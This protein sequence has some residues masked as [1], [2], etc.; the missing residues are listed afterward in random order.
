MLFAAAIVFSFVASQVVLGQADIPCPYAS[1]PDNVVHILDASYCPTAGRRCIVNKRCQV[2]NASGI[3][4][5]QAVGSL[6]ASKDMELI[7]DGKGAR[8]DLSTLELP[9]AMAHL[10][11][12]NFT[13]F[14]LPA[15]LVWPPNLT[16]LVMDYCDLDTIPS[17]LPRTLTSL[18]ISANSLQS[19]SELRALPLLYPA[20]KWLD[21]SLNDFTELV[22]LDWRQLTRMYV[23]ILTGQ[24]FTL[25]SG[26]GFNAKLKTI[27][28]VMLD[29]AI[30]T[31]DLRNLVLGNWTM[32]N[33]TFKALNTALK[34]NSTVADSHVPA[35][36]NG[37]GYY[38]YDT[39]IMSSPTTC[40]TMQGQIQEL[41]SDKRFRDPGF[42][43][44]TF[45]V[46]VLPDLISIAESGWWSTEFVVGVSVGGAALVS[47][48]V[49]FIMRRRHL[50]AQRELAA[51]QEQYNHTQT[52]TL[53][54]SEEE[55]LD[56]KALTLIR[57]DEH[58]LAFERKLGSGAFADVWLARFQGEPVAVKKLHN[59]RVSLPQLQSFVAEIQLLSSFDS[60][61]IVK[62]IGAAWTRPSD[63]KCVMELM[64]GGDLKD[65]LHHHNP[66]EFTWHD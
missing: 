9:P 55:G 21:I 47:L 56:V 30:L 38:Y 5:F 36:R 27:H 6:K 65:Y 45:Q 19:N 1:L 31:L 43:S 59:A 2:V 40:S 58:D 39:A 28:N 66:D 53:T 29:P 8:V 7:L 37:I 63:V 34:P 18:D 51:I 60:P 35:G 12:W 22:D 61:Y 24:S 50:K 10:A 52:P 44:A 20:L 57:L 41:W 14:H 49:F 17:N 48:A 54:T 32:N 64:A 13:K 11:F 3:G 46:C 62:L 16:T 42:N 4:A 23:W 26:L 15:R 25:T 33:D